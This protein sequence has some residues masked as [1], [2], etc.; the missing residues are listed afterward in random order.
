MQFDLLNQIVLVLLFVT[1]ILVIFSKLGLPSVLGYLAAGVL[2]GPGALN[3]LS[4]EQEMGALSEV[5]IIL[6]MFMIGLDFSWSRLRRNLKM[7]IGIG[8]L[9]TAAITA[10]TM[11]WFMKVSGQGMGAS[12]LIGGAA[13]MSSTAVVSKQLIDQKEFYDSHGKI[14]FGVTLFQDFAGIIFLALIPALSRSEATPAF[15]HDLII[16]LGT[17]FAVLI[18]IYVGGRKVERSLMRFIGG[19]KSSEIFVL[20][21]LL[22]IM[23]AAWISSFFHLPTMIGVFLAGMIIG[24]T[25]FRH[26]VEDDMRPFHDIMIGI[27]FIVMGLSLKLPVIF[28]HFWLILGLLGGIILIKLFLTTLIVSLYSKS[29]GNGLRVGLV[30]SNCDEFSLILVILGIKEKIIDSTLGNVLLIV[31]ILSLMISTLLIL[32]NKSMTF[33]LL[34]L[35]GLKQKPEEQEEKETDELADLSNHIILCGFG[36]TGKNI[37][38]I[39]KMTGIA[40]AAID[41]DPQ[42]VENA[43]A[44]G[45]RALYGDATNLKSLKSA[46][47]DKARALFIT[48]DNHAQALKLLHKI[49]SE[50]PLL[51]VIVRVHQASHME[52]ILLFGATAVFSDGLGISLSMRQEIMRALKIPEGLLQDEDEIIKEAFKT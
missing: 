11:L 20:T 47:I 10:A 27:F 7:V 6:M 15:L 37:R 3:I 22:T 51:P 35:L 16:T 39:L 8:S 26:K 43:A 1:G 23:G 12:F 21:T 36:E 5:G 30:L 52:D 45:C 2:I 24:E 25:E 50:Y 9:I 14:A 29:L 40:I 17:V 18:G 4:S 41:T 49:R 48:F 34:S 19:L 13:A 32:Y 28:M 31:F 33:F 42:H 44:M 46:N 38:N